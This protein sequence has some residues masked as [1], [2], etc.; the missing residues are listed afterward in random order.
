VENKI[1]YLRLCF[2]WRTH[3]AT[4]GNS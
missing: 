4:E 2:W 1:V 3:F